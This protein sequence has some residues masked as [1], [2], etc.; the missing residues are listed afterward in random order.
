M[1]PLTAILAALAAVAS[2]KLPPEVERGLERLSTQRAHEFV[3]DQE[4]ADFLRL[5][6]DADEPALV[7]RVLGLPAGYARTRALRVLGAT[8]AGRSQ[9]SALDYLARIP[10][11]ERPPVAESV[12]RALGERAFAEAK[13]SLAGLPD[14]A[15]RDS[16][17]LAL[18]MLLAKTD[19]PGAEALAQ[20]LDDKLKAR[21][22][23]HIGY[24]W[25]LD[26]TRG[27][28][29][30]VDGLGVTDTD[31]RVQLINN[32]AFRLCMSR[33][34]QALVLLPMFPDE[35][36]PLL[37]GMLARRMA[38]NDLP[39]ALAWMSTLTEQADRSEALLALADAW[40]ES[41]PESARA[42]VVEWPDPAARLRLHGIVAYRWA[43][44]DPEAALAW[45]LTLEPEL[46]EDATSKVLNQM[47]LANP[48]AAQRALMALPS[49]ADRDRLAERLVSNRPGSRELAEWSVRYPDA[50]T[51]RKLTK[52]AV[53]GWCLRLDDEGRDEAE[54]WVLALPD[55]SL[56]GEAAVGALDGTVRLIE[57]REAKLAPDGFVRLLE[58][59]GDEAARRAQARRLADLWKRSYPDDPRRPFARFLEERGGSEPEGAR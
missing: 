20:G 48:A 34:E 23:R 57:S 3:R 14:D 53:F 1:R 36:R 19:A 37:C 38:R 43:A 7:E 58:A 2:A 32:L 49:G 47:A 55:A 39:K 46:R 52:R 30:W 33:P 45:A 6:L 9:S 59:I 28:L 24:N 26:D 5:G 22:W 21:V 56:R 4:M 8:L 13:A 50:A 40:T 51:A 27:F 41:D 42:T 17:R 10:Q 35:V 31:L 44:R 12:Y 15:T 25:S 11:A 16:A 18:A 29:R 54:S